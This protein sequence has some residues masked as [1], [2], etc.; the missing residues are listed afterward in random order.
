MA[1]AEAARSTALAAAGAHR[2]RRL[3]QL[4]AEGEGLRPCLQRAWHC[5]AELS[6]A[7]VDMKSKVV[8]P[9]LQQRGAHVHRC[10]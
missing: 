5:N 1:A 10:R 7:F 3:G 4:L 6:S 2:R 8:D 9:H